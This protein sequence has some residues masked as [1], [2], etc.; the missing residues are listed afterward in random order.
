MNRN[1][2]STCYQ[3]QRLVPQNGKGNISKNRSTVDQLIQKGN[4]HY[5]VVETKLRKGSS[6][7]TTG[8]RRIEKNVKDGNK[9][10]EVRSDNN[11]LG[12]KKGQTIQV[13]EYEVKYKYYR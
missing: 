3:H 9:K 11:E 8:Q 7:L 12:L 1:D 5:K 13:D 6:K 4:D 10:F 2:Q